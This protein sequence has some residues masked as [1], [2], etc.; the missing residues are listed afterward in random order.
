MEVSREEARRRGVGIGVSV[1]AVCVRTRHGLYTLS[2]HLLVN[3][4]PQS[5]LLPD[6]QNH[7]GV[8]IPCLNLYLR[9]YR[10]VLLSLYVARPAVSWCDGKRTCASSWGFC[11]FFLCPRSSRA[12]GQ[13]ARPRSLLL[14]SIGSIFVAHCQLLSSSKRLFRWL[15]HCQKKKKSYIVIC[16]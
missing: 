4:C 2:P 6:R 7:S 9:C 3:Y 15:G 14:G 10:G 5:R 13:D 11:L 16:L 8:N 1:A 12:T